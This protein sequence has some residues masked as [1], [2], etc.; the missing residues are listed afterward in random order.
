MWQYLGSKGLIASIFKDKAATTHFS[1]REQTRQHSSRRLPCLATAISFAMKHHSSQ[2]VLLSAF[3]LLLSFFSFT[4]AQ[5]L[6]ALRIQT[7]GDSITKGSG[8]SDGNGYRKRLRNKLTHHGFAVDM[9]GSLRNGDMPDNDHEGHS[10]KYLADI[11]QYWKRSIQARPNVV[12]I[13]A[14]TNNMDKEVDL[15][16]APRLIES[17]IDDIF[18]AAS[19]AAIL[20]APVIWANSARMQANTDAFNH[21]LEQIILEKQQA[22][23]HILSVRTNIGLPDL[24]DMKHPNNAGYEKMASAWYSAVIEAQGRGWLSK[25]RSVSPNDLPGMGL[26]SRDNDVSGTSSCV[27]GNWE[28]AGTV[29]DGP[30]VWEERGVIR[31]PVEGASRDRLILVDLNKDGIAD[32]I[33]PS[34]DGNVTAW[35]NGGKPGQWTSLGQINPPWSKVTGDM[36]RMADVDGDGRA[37]MIVLY[38]DGAAKVWR[39]VDNGKRFESLDSNW[40]T[41]LASRDKVRFEDVDGDGYADYVILYAEGAVKWARNTR[42]NGKDPNKRNW[43]PAETIAP[44]PDGVP[45]DRVRLYDLDGDKKTGE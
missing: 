19:D 32:Y 11:A 16:I 29:F 28:R 5:S 10:G 22:G 38:Q 30:R 40:A 9:I 34:K 23:K 37:D 18:S 4:A 3:A 36:I 35:I 13:H 41:G 42:N 25:P 21:Q 45:K 1:G 7:L 17:I 24:S 12:L 43:E 14:G 20:V 8:S 15:A 31:A 26:G 6:P 27:G 44:G 33:L 2:A 39:N